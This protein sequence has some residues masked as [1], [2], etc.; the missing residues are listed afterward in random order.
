MEICGHEVIALGRRPSS[1]LR[2]P[3]L[4]KTRELPWQWA[5]SCRVCPYPSSCLHKSLSTFHPNQLFF[6]KFMN[7]FVH[8]V[9]LINYFHNVCGVIVTLPKHSWKEEGHKLIAAYWYNSTPPPPPQLGQSL[10]ALTASRQCLR[11]YICP[12]S[13]FWLDCPTSSHI[14]SQ[15]L[16]YGL[17]LLALP[18]C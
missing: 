6:L 7:V 8:A 16:S 1:Q 4:Q 12:V 11:P 3:Y 15:L 10:L 13:S 9:S 17:N 2:S 5:A 18:T 14:Y